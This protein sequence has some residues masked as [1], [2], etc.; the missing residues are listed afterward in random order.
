MTFLSLTETSGIEPN[1]TYKG[2]KGKETIS[3]LQRLT[4]DWSQ[5]E[6]SL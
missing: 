6:R 4:A 5:S 3:S 1:G 2:S